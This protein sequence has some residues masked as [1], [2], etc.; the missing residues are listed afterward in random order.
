MY[1]PTKNDWILRPL[2]LFSVMSFIAILS[3]KPAQSKQNEAVT[4]PK[5]EEVAENKE[6]V[7]PPKPEASQQPEIPKTEQVAAK[8]A[9]IPGLSLNIPAIN[10]NIP[11][12]QTTLGKNGELLVP[13]NPNQAAWYKLGPKIGAAGTALITGHLDAN[14]GRAGV[15]YNLRNLTAGDIIKVGREDGSVAAFKIDKLEVYRQD[16]TFP[17]NEVYRTS[18][19]SA[20]RIITCHGT[21]N[22]ET[23]RYSHNLVVYASLVAIE[24]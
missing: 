3:F 5:I 23:G 1:K 10:I 20:V 12:G 16:S 9:V 14:G 8:P 13:A 7:E 11:L 19:S 22:P 17:W 21:Y 18:G 4:Q 2:F 24:A 15:F 6:V